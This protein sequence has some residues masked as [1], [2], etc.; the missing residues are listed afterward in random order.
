M[1]NRYPVISSQNFAYFV[2]FTVVDWLP[3]FQQQGYRIIVLD[4]L[5]YVRSHKQVQLNAYV[6]MPTHIRCILA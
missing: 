5:A 1:P 4:S 3:L 2:T 6:I